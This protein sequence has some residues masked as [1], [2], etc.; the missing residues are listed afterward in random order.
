MKP[1]AATYGTTCMSSILAWTI[2]EVCP[3][4]NLGRNVDV[5]HS[6]KNRAY[7]DLAST[8]IVATAVW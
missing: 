7:R 4:R 5:N 1:P 8:G 2:R 3:G 6:F